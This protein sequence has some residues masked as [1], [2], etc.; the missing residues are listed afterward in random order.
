MGVTR[1]RGQAFLTSGTVCVRALNAAGPRPASL[2][3]Q[4][5]KDPPDSGFVDS[6][7]VQHMEAE[8]HAAE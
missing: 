5:V 7:P 4:S 8:Q 6:I 3:V 1:G 2:A